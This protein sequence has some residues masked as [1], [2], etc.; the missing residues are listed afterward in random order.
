[1][2]IGSSKGTHNHD[3]PDPGFPIP[4]FEIWS[5]VV[6]ANSNLILLILSNIDLKY[7][8]NGFQDNHHCFIMVQSFKC[9]Y[10]EFYCHNNHVQ[11]KSKRASY[12]SS[13]KLFKWSINMGIDANLASL[14]ICS[15]I[16][17][18][19][20]LPVS[21]LKEVV[22]DY[23]N[24]KPDSSDLIAAV[25]KGNIDE[26]EW[27]KCNYSSSWNAINKFKMIDA[28]DFAA[29]DGHLHVFLLLFT[30]SLYNIIYMCYGC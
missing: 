1:M 20:D 25:A 9:L 16:C 23:P 18:N 5:T 30:K 29:W 22:L 12:I 21:V 15:L 4:N 19:C 3:F 28:V 27:L 24:W 13:L 7:E 8:Q 14:P 11:F 26:L 6:T 10:K 2:I 17:Q